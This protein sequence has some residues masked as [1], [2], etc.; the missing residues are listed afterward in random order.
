MYVDDTSV[1]N[2]GINPNE[3]K[4]SYIS[5]HM[6]SN[7]AIKSNHPY[8]NSGKNIIFFSKQRKVDMISLK[9]NIKNRLV[10]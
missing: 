4:N 10:K 8:T 5:L 7:M 9:A 1:L 2:M 6:A 3:F